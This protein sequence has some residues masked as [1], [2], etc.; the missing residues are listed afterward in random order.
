MV[1]ETARALR[2]LEGSVP[3]FV[4]ASVVDTATGL[5]L[6][7]RTNVDEFDL[8]G[9]C[10]AHAEMLRRVTT[11]T[12][13]N[14]TIVMRE[15]PHVHFV[16]AIDQSTFFYLATTTFTDLGLVHRLVASQSQELA[17]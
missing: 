8:G 11:G 9:A 5:A 14:V 10:L 7:A 17:A 16:K 1:D 13:D 6:G 2:W 3:G 15:G 12:H 4:A